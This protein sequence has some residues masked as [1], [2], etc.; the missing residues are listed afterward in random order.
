MR[1]S[2]LGIVTLAFCMSIGVA[3]AGTFSFTGIFTQDDQLELFQFT[4]PSASLVVRTWG[5]AGGTNANG[6]LILP[7]GFDPILSVFD[8]TGGLLSTSPLVASNNDGAGVD[9]DPTTGNAFDS[10]LAL[11]ALSP[12]GTYLLVLSQNDNAPNNSTYG[13]GFSQTGAGNF[14][15]GEFGCGGTAPFCDATPAQRTGSWAVDIT[16]VRDAIDIT[17]DGGGGATA[18]EPASMLLLCTGL[19]GLA[20][21][22]RRKKQV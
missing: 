20:L 21:L 9:T 1:L 2:R 17:N 4:A 6:Q 16:G 15:A 22:R 11:S 3:T 7:G 18:P 19:S 12:G 5:Y 14:T 10:L 13:D 8:A